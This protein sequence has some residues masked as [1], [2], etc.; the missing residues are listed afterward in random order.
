MT[1]Q[2]RRPYLTWPWIVAY[3][4]GAAMWALI[5]GL[6]GWVVVVGLLAFGVLCAAGA[7]NWLHEYPFWED[8]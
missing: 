1:A 6:L 3:C 2:E 5:A 7:A 4:T 8:K